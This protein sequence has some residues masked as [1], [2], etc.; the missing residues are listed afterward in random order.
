MC[1]PRNGFG[2]DSR[3][4][5]V[6]ATAA[7]TAG[8][9]AVVGAGSGHARLGQHPPQGLVRPPIGAAVVDGGG[10]VSDPPAGRK[11]RATVSTPGPAGSGS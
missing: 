10:L 5:E 1:A 11:A 9:P 6:V 4:A 3:A 7:A 2:R 8:A